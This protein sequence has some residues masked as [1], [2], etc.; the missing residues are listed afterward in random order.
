[1]LPRK[2]RQLIEALGPF[3]A[4]AILV[5]IG[6]AAS[7]AF[8][9]P[10]NFQ[11]IL[12]NIAPVGLAAIGMTFVITLGGIDLSVGST[13]A[14]LGVAAIVG[15]GE[16]A[17]TSNPNSLEVSLGIGICILGGG[18][19]GA[20]NG[21]MVTWGKVAPFIATLATMAAYKSLAQTIA[22]DGTVS[23]RGDLFSAIGTGGVPL[24]REK[25]RVALM[26]PYP[27]L[28]FGVAA[29]LAHLLLRR[30]TFGVTVRAIGDNETAARYGGIPVGRT[31]LMTYTLCG[32]TAGIGS[33]MTTSYMNSASHADTGRLW[34]LDA[35]AA[36]VIGGTRMSGGTGTIVGTVIGVLMLGVIDNLVVIFDVNPSLQGLLKGSIIVAAVLLQ[37]G[38]K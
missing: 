23:V 2:A 20:L 14:L 35:I 29:L 5:G 1:M 16:V 26:L 8:R 11:N 34:E 30:T 31:R 27:V 15:M 13:A 24:I 28:V 7:P 12:R 32:L 36:V 21:A 4:L 9:D 3:F 22:N 19:L 17:G 38:R 10:V 33:L 25:G 6:A 37:R 18:L